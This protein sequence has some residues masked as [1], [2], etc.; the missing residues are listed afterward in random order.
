M[1]DGCSEWLGCGKAARVPSPTM[2]LTRV[3][4]Q[5]AFPLCSGLLFPEPEAL[6]PSLNKTSS[7]KYLNLMLLQGGLIPVTAAFCDRLTV[8]YL[9]STGKSRSHCFCLITFIWFLLIC[10]VNKCVMVSCL[11]SHLWF[12]RPKAVYSLPFLFQ[13]LKL[14]WLISHVGLLHRPGH[15]FYLF[16][17]Y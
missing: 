6:C 12:L 17:N 1:T 11:P 13:K 15:S 14:I 3:S 9:C 16:K 2:F 7:M 4:I 8:F 10:F 5:K